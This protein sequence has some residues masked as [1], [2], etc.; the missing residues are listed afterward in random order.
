M[1]CFTFAVL[2]D[3]QAFR[4]M[5]ESGNANSESTNGTEWRRNNNLVS[6]LNAITAPHDISFGIINGDMTE[7]GRLDSWSSV[8]D[9]YSKL[10]F[11]YYFGLGN[12]DYQNNEADCFEWDWLSYDGCALNSASNMQSQFKR[13]KT[14][15]QNFS[16]DWTDGKGSLAY[17]WDYNGV[18]F[19]Q[20]QNHPNYKVRLN[21]TFGTVYYDIIPSLTWLSNDLRTAK[22][23]GVNDIIL[24]FHKT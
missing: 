17:S 6:A 23:R 18:H 15:L 13:Y 5:K 12:H 20:L 10:K 3:P 8:F 22:F 1:A 4:L 2:A 14:E 16:S 7:Y 11:H 19:V 9:V 24:N 21:G